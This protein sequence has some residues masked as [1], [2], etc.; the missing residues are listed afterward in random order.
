[1]V[2]AG[3][4]T[5]Q[6]KKE[7]D[8]IDE[9]IDEVILRALGLDDVFDL[10]YDTYKTLLKERMMADRMGQKMDSGESGA[11]TDEYKRVKTKVGR[12]RLNKKKINVGAFKTK[13]SKPASESIKPKAKMLP[14]STFS[15]IQKSIPLKKE[16]EVTQQESQKEQSPSTKKEPKVAQ[17]EPQ[18]EKKPFTYNFKKIE[19]ILSDIIKNLKETFS[20]EKNTEKEK[21][22]EEGRK[23]KKER[24]STLEK[25]I[26][27]VAKIGKKILEPLKGPLDY[28]IN[29]ITYTFLGKV[30]N[31]IL[32]WISNPDN[33]KKMMSIT[34]FLK[35]WWPAL[36]GAYVI[37]GTSLGGFVSKL[38]F[39]VG[40]FT[41]KMLVGAIPKLLSLAKSP[42]GAGALLLGAGAA[43]PML[44]PE[45]V[46]EQ[47]RKTEE[48][49]KK[50]GKDKVRAELERQANNPNL[51]ERLTGQDAE[52]KEQLYKI[53]TG[54]TKSYRKGGKVTGQSGTDIRGAGADTQLIAAQP[55]EIVINKPTVNALGPEFFLA[56]NKKHGGSGAN[57]PKMAKNIQTAAGG[58][59]VLPAFS[60]GGQVGEMKG[61]QH[62]PDWMERPPTERLYGSSGDVSSKTGTRP[63]IVNRTPAEGGGYLG[64]TPKDVKSLPNL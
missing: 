43:I 16:P 47:E 53:E 61:G 22:Q 18:K 2:E 4:G 63:N 40:A 62:L 64:G 6:G 45:T 46:N 14:G 13:T 34:R 56:L 19:N 27:V 48:K 52:A 23:K 15:P 29:W 31:N 20:F 30:F 39:T 35:D 7:S 44:M 9:K 8:L 28:I 21:N 42:L 24:E 5:Y 26:G 36:V 32:N 3:K 11:V 51:Y 1:M 55:G 54:E 49:V 59:L 58:G 60:S 50:Q 41:A 25:T 12:F 10:D 37:F 38:I 33:S 57:K 17:Q